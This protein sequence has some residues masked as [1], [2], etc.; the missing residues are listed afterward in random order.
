MLTYLSHRKRHMENPNIH[1]IPYVRSRD[2]K[3][4]KGHSKKVVSKEETTER[5]IHM[6]QHS[7][8]I[9]HAYIFMFTGCV[10]GVQKTEKRIDKMIFGVVCIAL[11]AKSLGLMTRLRSSNLCEM[12]LQGDWV[13]ACYWS[14][15]NTVSLIPKHVVPL[16]LFLHNSSNLCPPLRHPNMPLIYHST[17][18]HRKRLSC[19]QFLP[20]SLGD[21]IAQVVAALLLAAIAVLAACH[22]PRWTHRIHILPCHPFALKMSSRRLCDM[23]KTPRSFM[24][25]LVLFLIM[26]TTII[27]PGHPKSW[28]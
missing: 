14:S 3:R 21:A 2:Q 6:I 23:S 16:P 17:A 15:S 13:V 4:W 5:Y 18:L 26:L 9:H 8:K 25:L 7:C 12:K 28:K 11:H 19:H 27:V 1:N 10:N 20:T 24:S 22:H